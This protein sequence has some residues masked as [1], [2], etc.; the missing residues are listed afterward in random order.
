MSDHT[1]PTDEELAEW[2]ADTKIAMKDAEIW[3]SWGVAIPLRLKRLD[4]SIAE[5]ERL[6]AEV[7]RLYV[8]LAGAERVIKG[9]NLILESK[10]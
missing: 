9:L 5:V 4:R 8:A 2:K 3:L 7:E 6:R 1:P 10:D